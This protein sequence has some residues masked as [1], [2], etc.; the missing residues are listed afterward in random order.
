MICFVDSSGIQPTVGGRQ[1]ALA[2]RVESDEHEDD[3]SLAERVGDG[4]REFSGLSRR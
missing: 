4:Q 3:L 1:G 2:G